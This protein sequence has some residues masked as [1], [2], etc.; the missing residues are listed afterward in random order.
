VGALRLDAE[1]AAEQIVLGP[2]RTLGAP[3]GVQVLAV[4]M[5]VRLLAASP[6]RRPATAILDRSTAER[7][8]VTER[9]DRFRV[10]PGT[11][12]GSALYQASFVSFVRERP[13]R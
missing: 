10:R 2:G 13:R 6:T 3:D 9:R 11:Q 4:L 8:V 7:E 1:R 12:L 5:R